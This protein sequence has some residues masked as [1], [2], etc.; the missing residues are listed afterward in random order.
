MAFKKILLHIGVEKTGSTSIQQACLKNRDALISHH[1]LIPSKIGNGNHTRLAIYA[2][3]YEQGLAKRF[4]QINSEEEMQVWRD[5]LRAEF[6]TEVKAS[7]AELLI[8]SCEWLAHMLKEPAEFQRLVDLLTEVS[9]NIEV[10]MYIRR[11]DQLA[12][13]RYSTALKAGHSYPFSFPLTMTSEGGLYDFLGIYQRWTTYLPNLTVR[14]FD[15]QSLHE[16]DL[17]ADFFQLCQLDHKKVCTDL[18]E[19]PDNPSLSIEGQLALIEFNKLM[20][21]NFLNG[22]PIER[23]TARALTNFRLTIGKLMPGKFQPCTKTEA[24]EFAAMFK[25]SNEVLRKTVFPDKDQLFTQDFS[26]YP[27]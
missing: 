9:D 24:M 20:S 21:E 11:Q 25:E 18:S 23:K 8:L 4:H 26:K 27:D 15:R 10:V 14:I 17:L 6:L 2:A 19:A 12:V 1:C 5:E 22:K 13:S 16:Q 3:N 7:D